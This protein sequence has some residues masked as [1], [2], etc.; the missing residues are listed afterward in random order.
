M[1]ARLRI[2]EIEGVDGAFFEAFDGANRY[3][4]LF[5]ETGL[6]FFDAQRR[7]PSVDLS[8]LDLSVFHTFRVE[9]AGSTSAFTFLV[10]G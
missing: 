10:D 6:V 8:S 7:G 3:G 5:D 1:E 4:P 9:S 2:L